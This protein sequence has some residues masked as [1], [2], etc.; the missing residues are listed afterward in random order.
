MSI[1]RLRF[2]AAIGTIILPLALVLFSPPTGAAD[3]LATLNAALSKV[4]DGERVFIN[5]TFARNLY[6]ETMTIKSYGIDF[7]NGCKQA[8]INK[9]A[10]LPDT[11]FAVVRRHNIIIVGSPFYSVPIKTGAN[12]NVLYIKRIA[13]ALHIIKKYTPKTFDAISETMKQNHGYIIIDNV[14][15]SDAGLAFAAFIPRVNQNQFIIMVSSTLLLL[16]DLFNDYDVAAQLVHEMHGHAVDFYQRGSTDEA[17]A[18]TVQ[19]DF[20]QSVGDEKF[21][22]VNN[23]TGNLRTRIKLKLSTMGTYVAPK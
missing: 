17:H 21:L 14:C 12:N 1:K 2:K 8:N 13:N 20:A 18:F 6:L 23:R 10:Q 3:K 11:D 7:L 5:K 16:P 22:D 9:H 19:S 4:Q 15:P